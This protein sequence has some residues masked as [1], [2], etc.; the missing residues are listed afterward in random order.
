M[1]SCQAQVFVCV[2]LHVCVYVRA[3]ACMKVQVH[4]SA[5]ESQFVLMANCLPLP[6]NKEPIDSVTHRS[7]LSFSTGQCFVLV[8]STHTHISKF[9]QRTHRNTQTTTPPAHAYIHALWKKRLDTQHRYPF[10]T[11]CTYFNI[12]FL[13]MVR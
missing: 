13:K 9:P 2:L 7:F 8:P 10:L 1:T 4:Y 12:E 5:L 6:V 3:R 11:R